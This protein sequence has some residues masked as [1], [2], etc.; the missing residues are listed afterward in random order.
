MAPRRGPARQER[1]PLGGGSGPQSGPAPREGPGARLCVR[2]PCP[3]RPWAGPT[4]PRAQ[5]GVALADPKLP[6]PHL[7]V[8]GP[9]GPYEGVS[10]EPCSGHSQLTPDPLWTFPTLG[11]SSSKQ[12]PLT[13]CLGPQPNCTRR[14]LPPG[15][16]FQA[17]TRG[18]PKP[19]GA[20]GAGS[21]RVPSDPSA[22]EEPHFLQ[23]VLGVHI[24]STR[25]TWGRRKL[26]TRATLGTPKGLPGTCKSK[27]RACVPPSATSPAPRH[28]VGAQ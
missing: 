26:V 13:S 20:T 7:A 5:A 21:F 1:W 25:V 3:R 18:W 28:P 17:V 14:E 15:S 11:T 2:S 19:N 9:Q 22:G 12:L 24:H 10:P 8:P 4:L 23:F 6:T 27:N 16:S